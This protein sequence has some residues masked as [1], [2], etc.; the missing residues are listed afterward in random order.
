MTHFSFPRGS[1]GDGGPSTGTG[2]FFSSHS[3]KGRNRDLERKNLSTS[4]RFFPS[5]RIAMALPTAARL[6]LRGEA[7]SLRDGALSLRDE[8]LSL[9]DG[10]LSLRDGALSLRDEALS[11]R[12]G[13]LS[14]RD[15]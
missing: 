2:F 14:L 11:L 7:L 4:G 3:R 8:A 10:A 12:D 13:A 1:A 5:A 9:R 6:S 15:E